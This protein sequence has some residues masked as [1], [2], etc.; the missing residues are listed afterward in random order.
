[1]ILFDA[2]RKGDVWK[3]KAGHLVSM[4]KDSSAT[5][6]L[7]KKPADLFPITDFSDK[8]HDLVKTLA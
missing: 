1:M 4:D 2:W 8:I 5:F 7:T 6:K 3:G